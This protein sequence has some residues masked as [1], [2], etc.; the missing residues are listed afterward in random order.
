MRVFGNSR[1]GLSLIQPR[2]LFPGFGSL[3]SMPHKKMPVASAVVSHVAQ[4]AVETTTS[5]IVPQAVALA[6]VTVVPP[7]VKAVVLIADLLFNPKW[8]AIRGLVVGGVGMAAAQFAWRKIVHNSQEASLRRA[9]EHTERLLQQIEFMRR[10]VE[11]LLRR[12][13]EVP[14]VVAAS[15]EAIETISVQVIEAG[16][17]A[18]MERLELAKKMLESPLFAVL[19]ERSERSLRNLEAVSQESQ[20]L[21]GRLIQLKGVV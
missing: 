16:V 11:E 18:L 3:G 10:G 21:Q 8:E 19:K 9:E 17:T 13:E 15:T 1:G 2:G 14:L 5:I 12:A 20:I 4:K 7:P 6:E